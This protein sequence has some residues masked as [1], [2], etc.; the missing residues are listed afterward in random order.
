MT[1]MSK[2]TGRLMG[3]RPGRCRSL[4]QGG[5]GLLMDKKNIQLSAPGMVI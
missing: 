2:T 5:L 4:N 3:V 1:C